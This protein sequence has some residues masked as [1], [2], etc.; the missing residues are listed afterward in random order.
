VA[1]NVVFNE[2]QISGFGF[3]FSDETFRV[4][5]CYVSLMVQWIS[6][7]RL[8]FLQFRMSVL[9]SL[10]DQEPGKLHVYKLQNLCSKPD[11]TRVI[12]SR[13]IGLARHAACIRERRQYNIKEFGLQNRGRPK[14]R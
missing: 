6:R 8:N 2:Q 12:T 13:R 7:L 5:H 9:S 4:E 14:R 11:I 1:R 3:A 10:R